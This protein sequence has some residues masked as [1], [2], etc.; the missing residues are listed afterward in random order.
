MKAEIRKLLGSD[1]LIIGSDRCMKL[2]RSGELKKVM[3][4]SNC[5]PTLAED[6]KHIGGVSGAEVIELDV[7]NEELGIYC[8]KP[9]NI[10]VLG[11]RA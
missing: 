10:N 8:K 2:L 9:F 6:V 4:A 3:L 5:S 1:K 11:I 7:P